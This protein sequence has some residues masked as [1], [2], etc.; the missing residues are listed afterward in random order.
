MSQI[1]YQFFRFSNFEKIQ[2]G[3][4]IFFFLGFF[5]AF[6]SPIKNN[7][8]NMSFIKKTFSLSRRLLQNK[9]KKDGERE[10]LL[11]NMEL[12]LKMYI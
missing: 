3:L 7:R 5:R 11:F 8:E 9:K 10:R 4:L 6:M 12:F 1:I 2:I